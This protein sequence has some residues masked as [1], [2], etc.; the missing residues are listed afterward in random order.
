MFF[1]SARVLYVSIFF[2]LLDPN[3]VRGILS[4]NGAWS[5]RSSLLGFPVKFIYSS[6]SCTLALERE[7]EREKKQK[8]KQNGVHHLLFHVRHSGWVHFL[9]LFIWAFPRDGSYW[10]RT[11]RWS[12]KTKRAALTYFLSNGRNNRYACPTRPP[13]FSFTRLEFNEGK[14]FRF[15]IVRLLKLSIFDLQRERN[16]QRTNNEN[17]TRFQKSLVK[18]LTSNPGIRFFPPPD[19]ISKPP[20]PSDWPRL[21]W[22]T[23][24]RVTS[25]SPR[26]PPFS[27]CQNEH[28]HHGVILRLSRFAI[29]CTQQYH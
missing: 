11:A 22:P 10:R 13:K 3:Q 20:P 29:S 2:F 21:A 17:K 24:L 14:K 6:A 19:E 9:S 23:G 18:V 28:T 15:P 5:A 1:L 26:L 12:D 27:Y 8:T 7:R 25:S 4:D 16:R